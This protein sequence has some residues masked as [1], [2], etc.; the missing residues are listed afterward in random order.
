MNG[1]VANGTFV[2]GGLGWCNLLCCAGDVR[3]KLGVMA[4][5]G[6]KLGGLLALTIVRLL[7]Y[8]VQWVQKKSDLVGSLW[9]NL[10]ATHL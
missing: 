7:Y 1:T 10:S 6:Y 3:D 5:A 4:V 8:I 2:Y 9:S